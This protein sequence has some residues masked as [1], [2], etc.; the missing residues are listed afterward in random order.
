MAGSGAVLRHALA[1]AAEDQSRVVVESTSFDGPSGRR[2]F[3]RV[4]VGR[5]R[6]QAVFV[7]HHASDGD[8]RSALRRA[9]GARVGPVRRADAFFVPDDAERRA[10][11]G[12]ELGEALVSLVVSGGGR[13]GGGVLRGGGGGVACAD[14]CEADDGDRE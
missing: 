13:F 14:G 9:D 5:L 8:V 7:R 3:R 11:R 2:V 4:A 6:D 10:F 12:T 1:S